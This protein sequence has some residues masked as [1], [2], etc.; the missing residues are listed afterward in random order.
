VG[1]GTQAGFQAYTEWTQ[2]HEAYKRTMP[3]G[4]SRSDEIRT[5][6]TMRITQHFLHQTLSFNLF[7]FLGISDDD[8]YVIPSL[9][10]AF[11]D[12]FWTELGANIFSGSRSGTFGSL[13]DNDNIYLTVRYTF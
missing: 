8:L 5:I 7:T 6:A 11:S 3:A 12:N 9:R 4:F 2:V 13:K 1:Q 10:Y